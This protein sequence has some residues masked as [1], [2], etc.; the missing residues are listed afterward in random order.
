[1]ILALAFGPFAGADEKRS[2]IE[3]LKWN[4]SAGG[5]PPNSISGSRTTVSFKNNSDRAVKL[6]WVKYNGDLKLYGEMNP[7]TTRNQ[8][9][10]SNNSWL[11]TDTDDNPLG[12]FRTTHQPAVA[13]IPEHFEKPDL[14]S[15]RYTTRSKADALTWQ[16]EMRTAILELLKIEDLVSAKQ[17]NPLNTKTLSSEDRGTYYFQELE[18]N[19]TPV[20]R[21]KVVLTLPK[22]A[23]RSCPGV[24]AIAGHSGTRHSCYGA[25]GFATLLAEK[26]YATVS[27]KISQH[28]IRENGHTMMGERLWDLMRCVDLLVSLEQVDAKRIGCAGNSLGGEMAMWLGAM[29]SRITATVS[30]GFLTRMDQLEKNHCRCWKFAGLRQLADFSDIYAL[31]APRALLCQNGLKERPTW[32][33]VPLAREAMKEI[34]PIY[35]DFGT[36]ENLEFR[37]HEGGHVFDVPSL[38]AFFEKHLKDSN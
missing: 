25:G 37:A 27:T 36:A 1:L 35:A 21:I 23:D 18:I 9:T 4:P 38:I 26:G 29:D 24:V 14:R 10:V 6:F 19:S 3:H 20:S 28:S 5:L 13:V 15:K 7:G 32:F 34:E 17:P 16:R 31:A 2:D 11:V 12:Y 8:T 30:A 33:T 22:N